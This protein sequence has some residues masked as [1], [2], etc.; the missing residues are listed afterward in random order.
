MVKRAKPD[1]LVSYVRPEL[2]RALEKM[3]AS[4][5]LSV[6][7]LVNLALTAFVKKEGKS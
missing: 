2:K 1:K 3:A 6:S 4:R 7:T 5:G